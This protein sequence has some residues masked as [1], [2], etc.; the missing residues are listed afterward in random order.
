MANT[1]EVSCDKMIDP[2][3]MVKQFKMYPI[4]KFTFKWAF[5]YR[6][7]RAKMKLT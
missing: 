2:I 7:S 1:L 5:V 3:K 6:F 4:A